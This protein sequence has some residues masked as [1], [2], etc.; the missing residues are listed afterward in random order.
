MAT[1]VNEGEVIG[2]RPPT[3]AGRSTCRLLR[4]LTAPL[5]VSPVREPDNDPA[6]GVR[7]ITDVAN[8]SLSSS[9]NDPYTARQ[10]LNQVRS[11]LQRIG[12]LLFGDWNVV[13]GR[14]R[15]AGLGAADQSA[16][17]L[18]DGGEPPAFTTANTTRMSSKG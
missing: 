4:M 2:G 5:E 8:R 15:G 6:L 11:V 9:A 3:T 1:Y 16:R 7:I 13:D 12:P 10:A 14:R 18:G 17:T